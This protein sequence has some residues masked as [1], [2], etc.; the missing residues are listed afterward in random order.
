ML[1]F[2]VAGVPGVNETLFLARQASSAQ[3][4]IRLDDSYRLYCCSICSKGYRSDKAL[5]QHLSSRSHILRVAQVKDPSEE[6]NTMVKTVRLPFSGSSRPT[7]GK[8]IHAA[9]SEVSEDEWEE[10]SSDDDLIGGA[11]KS[12]TELTVNEPSPSSYM[13]DDDGN[14]NAVCEVDPLCCFM[15]DLKHEN[16]EYCIVHMHKQH[17]FFIP[18]VEYL[19][20]PE[21]F[22]TYLGLKVQI[23]H[24]KLFLCLFAFFP[25]I[26]GVD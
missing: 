6:R 12:L 11:A 20:D 26:V 9:E 3:D 14:D 8:E 21:G 17:G 18:D 2:Q 13:D 7:L 22:L 25:F 15:C 24:L 16:I 23:L 19:K 5:A 10:G 4:K 1:L